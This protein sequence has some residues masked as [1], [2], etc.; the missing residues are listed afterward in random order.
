MSDESFPRIDYNS[1][2]W[3]RIV[4]HLEDMRQDSVKY[5]LSKDVDFTNTNFH[6]GQVAIIDTILDW[7]PH[8]SRY[9]R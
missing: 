8:A 4:E 6:R 3:H 9:G 7:N 2:D 5:L 1:P